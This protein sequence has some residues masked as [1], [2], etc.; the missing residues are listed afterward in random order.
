VHGS[1]FDLAAG[2]LTFTSELRHVGLDTGL[3]PEYGAIF[4]D[5]RSSSTWRT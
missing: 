5:L 4:I 1:E 3:I 2:S